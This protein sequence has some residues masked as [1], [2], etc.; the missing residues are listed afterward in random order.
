[1]NESYIYKYENN[2]QGALYILIYCSKSAVRI[3]GDVFAHHQEHFTV[4]TISGS[5]YTPHKLHS[6]V[7]THSGQQPAAT[8]M[9]TT[10]YCKYSLKLNCV[11]CE[12]CTRLTL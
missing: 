3:S 2:Q 8:W 5:V 6:L 7:S 1:M 9:N 4:F 10:R 12:A 11:D